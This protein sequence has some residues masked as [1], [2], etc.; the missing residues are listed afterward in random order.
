MAEAA[1][2][3][4]KHQDLDPKSLQT[5]RA[6]GPQGELSGIPMRGENGMKSIFQI[7]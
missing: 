7:E 5:P 4:D 2:V 1:A 6:E 3:C